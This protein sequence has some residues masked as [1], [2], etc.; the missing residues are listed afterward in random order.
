MW[1]L[2]DTSITTQT[3]FENVEDFSQ[4]LEQSGKKVFGCVYTSNNNNLKIWKPPYLKNNLGGLLN[5][6]IEY[7][8]ENEKVRETVFA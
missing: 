4:I 2:A 5:F 1:A 8:R 7:I 3:I 6:E